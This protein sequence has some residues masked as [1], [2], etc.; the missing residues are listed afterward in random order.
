MGF[1]ALILLMIL[2]AG[3]PDLM[4]RALGLRTHAPY[5]WL[6]L[7]LYLTFRA[8]GYGA[9][10]WAIAV[11]LVEDCLS[12]DPLGTHGFVLGTTAWLLS[13]GRSHRGRL[14]GGPRL[15]L[16]ALG[17]LLA[18]WIYLFRII[19]LDGARG[20]VTAGAFVDAFPTAFFTAI[21]SLFFFPV[22]DRLGVLDD[23]CGRSRGLP[24]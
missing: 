12:L 3:V 14:E 20:G 7:A 8:R 24:T 19:P 11:G 16:T 6:L 1:P 15:L 13:E 21:L 23:L 5:V 18:G 10:G 2:A 4:P 9:V 17:S 22:L